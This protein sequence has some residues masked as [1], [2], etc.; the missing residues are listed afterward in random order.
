MYSDRIDGRRA[1]W[2]ATVLGHG[3]SDP[4]CRSH[5]G[6]APWAAWHHADIGSAAGYVARTMS[7]GAACIPRNSAQ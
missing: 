6:R 1:W 4:L 2:A 5:H 7:N 3:G